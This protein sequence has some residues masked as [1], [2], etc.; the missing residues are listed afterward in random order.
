LGKKY[1][2]EENI[3]MKDGNDKFIGMSEAS[4]K[5]EAFA[6]AIDDASA[7]RKHDSQDHIYQSLK[8]DKSAS[9]VVYDEY[10]GSI[11]NE[12]FDD[13]VSD[14]QLNVVG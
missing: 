11:Y 14:I 2:A 10:I 12:N 4:Q 1:R 7:D 3:E 13:D 9:S 5:S 6:I 8:T